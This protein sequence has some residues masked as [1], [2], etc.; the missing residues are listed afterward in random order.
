MTDADL[1]AGIAALTAY[2]QGIAPFESMFVP[3]SAYQTAVT[4][5]ITASDGSADQTPAGRQA[6]AQTA[7]RAAINSAGLGSQISNQQCHDGTAIVLAAVNK[8]VALGSD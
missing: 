5:I 3:A 8:S 1:A 4:D 7:M 6:V 2:V